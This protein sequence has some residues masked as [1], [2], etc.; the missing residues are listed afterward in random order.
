MTDVMTPSQRKKAMR[1]NRG[2]TK[3]ERALARALWDR[4]LRYYTAEGYERRTG[5]K[6]AGNPDL[7]FPGRRVLVFVDGCFWH[8]CPACGKAR[9]DMSQA[10]RAKIRA[11]AERDHRV[12]ALLESQG[13][14]VI[15]LWEHEVNAKSRLGPTAKR[16]AERILKAG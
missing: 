12:T 1:S 8:G 11:N 3:P 4:G 5:V 14:R 9:D 10:W 2:R 16:L 15:R 6:L 13:W 7:V